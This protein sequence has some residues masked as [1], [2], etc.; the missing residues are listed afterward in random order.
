[1]VGNQCVPKTNSVALQCDD[2]FGQSV[3]I[4]IQ[5]SIYTLPPLHTLNVQP[6]MGEPV[7]INSDSESEDEFNSDYD[8]YTS[9]PEWLPSEDDMENDR[10]CMHHITDC[11]CSFFMPMI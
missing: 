6:Y 1:M 5:C 2:D 4:G 11:I 10:Y 9:D 3:E 8:A 7:A